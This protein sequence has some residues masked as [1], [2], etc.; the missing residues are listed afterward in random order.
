M[1]I[2][3]KGQF[4]F[5]EEN[6]TEGTTTER[7]LHPEDR[8]ILAEDEECKIEVKV[9]ENRA[10]VSIIEQGSHSVHHRW[11]PREGEFTRSSIA[12]LNHGASF[13][14]EKQSLSVEFREEDKK[15]RRTVYWRKTDA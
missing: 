12:P 1:N 10:I 15:V 11:N 2:E 13:N 4:I 3:R 6:L 5:S 7:E 8:V 14:P 9:K